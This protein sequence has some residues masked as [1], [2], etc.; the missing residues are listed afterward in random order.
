MA[1]TDDFEAD[2][3]AETENY[4]VWRSDDEEEGPLFHVELGGVTLHLDSEEWDE[5]ILLIKIASNR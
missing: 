5:L 4:G 2:M 1:D 3:I